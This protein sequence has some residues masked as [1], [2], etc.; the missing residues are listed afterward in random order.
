ML[1]SLV[2]LSLADLDLPTGPSTIRESND[3]I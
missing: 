2:D 3:R 1:T